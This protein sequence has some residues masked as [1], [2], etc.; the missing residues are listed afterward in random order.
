MVN[1]FHTLHQF[2][3]SFPT[4]GAGLKVIFIP[5]FPMQDVRRVRLLF[6]G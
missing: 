4:I 3:T 5:I 1:K 2:L 6:D